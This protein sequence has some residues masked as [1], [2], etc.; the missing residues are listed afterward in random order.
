MSN[1]HPVLVTSD[2]PPDHG[3]VA[4]YL[5]ELVSASHGEMNVVVPLSHFGSTD[6]SVS[7]TMLFRDMWP[8]WWPMVHVCRD[9]RSTASCL[10]VSHVIPIGTAAMIAHWFGGPKFVVL[11]HGLD[12]QTAHAHFLKRMIARMV[13]RSASSVIVNSQATAKVV[14]RL[15]GSTMRLDV[16]TPGVSNIV[17][18]TREI[19]RAR[20]GVGSNEHV[21]LA[22][23]RLVERKGFDTLIEAVKGIPFSDRIR[24]VILGDGPEDEALRELARDSHH[25]IQFISLAS[26]EYKTEWFAAANVFCLPIKDRPNDMEGFGITSLE[27]ALAGLPVIIGRAGGTEEAVVDEQ[28]GLFVNG[29]DP[30]DVARAL[31]SLL[32]DPEKQR[33]MGEA[34]RKRALADFR[35]EDRWK[36]FQEIF[37]RIV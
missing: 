23:S 15:F 27:A 32:S 21:V 28:T 14:H 30:R 20:L 26:D 11:L 22:I 3:G 6:P 17:F 37:R 25:H 16:I 12:A 36:M 35:W 4:R 1:M 2:Y 29:S 18:P 10:L 9:L 19:A 13:L 31:V 33:R 24:V 8:R 5:S 34:G 7:A